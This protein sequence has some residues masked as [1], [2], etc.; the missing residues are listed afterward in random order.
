MQL[1]STMLFKHDKTKQGKSGKNLYYE[2]NCYY[3]RRRYK[4]SG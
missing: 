3:S 2:L 1:E 4:W